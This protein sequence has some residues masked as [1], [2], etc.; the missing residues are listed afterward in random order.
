[1]SGIYI[2]RARARVSER[3]CV[4]ERDSECEGYCERQRESES[5]R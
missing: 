1:M 5:E 4:I 3:V 2:E